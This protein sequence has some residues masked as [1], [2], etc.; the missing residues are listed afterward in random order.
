L[1]DDSIHFLFKKL[2]KDNHSSIHSPTFLK[3]LKLEPDIKQGAEE[4]GKITPLE[5]YKYDKYKMLFTIICG[6]L[7][8]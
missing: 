5:M 3:L 6:H 4:D 2:D 7:E 8:K 1:N